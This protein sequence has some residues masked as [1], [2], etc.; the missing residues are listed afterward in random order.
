MAK[1]WVGMNAELELRGKGM[2]AESG[3]LLWMTEGVRTRAE[4]QAFYD[5]YLAGGTLAA[6]PGTSNHEKGLAVDIACEWV[7]NA[8]RARLAKQWGLYT[9]VRGEPWHFE[10]D[11]ARLPLE[12]PKPV[13]VPEEDEDEMANDAARTVRWPNAVLVAREDGGTERYGPIPEYGNMFALTPSEKL[14]F[15]KITAAN[16]IDPTNPIAG[17]ILYNQKGQS[18]KFDQAAAAQY[19]KRGT[20]L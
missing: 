18:F 9:P 6:K 13:Y 20:L 14:G 2:I 7:N 1:T 3:G 19:R 17:Y 8:L 16:W 5:A 12:Q 4:Q 10:L 11:P 15:E